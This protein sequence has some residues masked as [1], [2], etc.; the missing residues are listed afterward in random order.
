MVLWM[1]HV[2]GFEE[3]WNIAFHTE[4]IEQGN[5]HGTGLKSTVMWDPPERVKFANN[6][7]SRAHFRR[8]RSTCSWRTSRGEG[9]PAPG[10][11]GE[12]HP[13]HGGG[14]R[15]KKGLDF[16]PP[17]QLLRLPP[18]AA[19]EERYQAHR[20]AAGGPAR[21]PGA[22][23]RAQGAPAHA[24]DLHEGG[25]PALH[26]QEAG[27]FSTRSSS[28]RATRASAAATSRPS[29]SPSS[30]PSGKPADDRAPGLRG[31]ARGSTTC[32]SRPRGAPLRALPHR[33]R[34]RRPLHHRH[35][36]QRPP[37]GSSP[38]RPSTAGARWRR[39]RPGPAQAPLPPSGCRPRAS[40]PSTPG[41]R[42]S[43]TP[44]SRW[45]CSSR[46]PRTR[47]TSPTATAT[48]SS[49]STRGGHPAQP[50]GDPTRQGDHVFVPRGHLHLP[51][52]PGLPQWWLW[53]ECRAAA[54]PPSGATRPGSCGWTPPLPPGLRPVRFLGP[55]DEGL[56]RQVVG[57]GQ[58][59]PRFLHRGL[60]LDVVGW[61]GSVHPSAFHIPR[62]P[63]PG[64]P[65]PPAPTW[66]GTFAMRGRWCAASCPG[67]W[68]ST[69]RRCPARTPTP[70]WT[71]DE[72]LLQPAAPSP[73]RRG[74]VQ[75][76]EFPPGRPPHGPH[77]GAC[78]RRRWA[79]PG[80]QRAG[81]DA[82]LRPAAHP[83]P[84][85]RRWRTGYQRS[86]LP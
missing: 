26:D 67:W 62:L 41:C 36:H 65:H 8:R 83:P 3:F 77:P 58:G 70:R 20:R 4:E 48:T 12:G 31:A 49:T 24:A 38:P 9:H 66:H 82:G 75:L 11:A 28:A 22:H 17:R 85:R 25:Q 50:A 84:G 59:L 10:I 21:A 86:F 29:S 2:M 19:A 39:P 72:F 64:G 1:K 68:T 57:S 40:R 44:T 80:H 37:H 55:W 23:R 81:G 5:Q 30:G 42:C 7:P 61:D 74:G 14:C 54:S 73:S 53:L 56:R 6:E 43:S 71:W 60:A 13:H 79:P 47:C 18:G 63:A 46:G 16:S 76:D 35:H 32:S 15:A 34:L 69:P 33:G 52:H 45:G 51:A 27:P 78:T